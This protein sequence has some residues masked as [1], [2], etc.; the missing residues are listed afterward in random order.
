[1]AVIAKLAA[2]MSPHL[3]P[4]TLVLFG[5]LP[6]RNWRTAYE[7]LEFAIVRNVLNTLG[8]LLSDCYKSFDD[9]LIE[10]GTLQA[11]LQLIK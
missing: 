7:L 9:V 5:P 6:E 10:P 4:Y 2:C 1:M 11:S 8:H 3:Y